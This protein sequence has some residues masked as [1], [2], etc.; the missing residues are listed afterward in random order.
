MRLNKE[1]FLKLKRG[2]RTKLITKAT[3]KRI[4]IEGQ[5]KRIGVNEV[6]INIGKYKPN[7]RID[8]LEIKKT[9]KVL[10]GYEVK[11][12][13]EDFRT[14]NKWENYL[15]L[16][17]ELFFVFDEHTYE[18]H[19]EEILEKIEDKA[20]VC[21]YYPD[22]DHTYFK[23]YPVRNRIE[24]NPEIYHVTLFNYMLRNQIKELNEVS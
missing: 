9:N 12:C 7:L 20:G 14:D 3:M 5:G 8:I 4:L 19:Q 11:S 16:L 13:I 24:P 17:H 18:K 10:I 6:N 21:I 2:E 1:N 15:D 22:R 23:K